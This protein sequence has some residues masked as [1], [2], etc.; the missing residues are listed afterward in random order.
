MKPITFG[1]ALLCAA[2][3]SLI[4]CSKSDTTPQPVNPIDTV[5][6]PPTATKYSYTYD[7]SFKSTGSFATMGAVQPDGKIIIANTTQVARLNQDGTL[8]NGFATGN[9]A[10]G[11]FHSLALQKDGKVLLGGSFTSFNGQGKA[12]YIRLNANGSVDNGFTVLPLTSVSAQPKIDI[13]S[14]AIQSDSKILLG[15]NFYYIVSDV[16]GATSGPRQIVRLSENGAYDP[17]FKH[18][19]TAS[20]VNCLRILADGKMLV[21]GQSVSVEFYPTPATYDNRNIV[22]KLNADG[23]VDP[24]FKWPTTTFAMRSPYT[25]LKAYGQTITVLDDGK[26]L[27]GGRFET[28][29]T[30]TADDYGGMVRLKADGSID[31]TMPKRGFTGVVS[32]LC[33]ASDRLVVG[34]MHDPEKTYTDANIAINQFNKDGTDNATF[35]VN[36]FTNYGDV[37][38]VLEDASKN[39][40]IFGKLYDKIVTSTYTFHGVVRLK[41]L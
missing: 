21:T 20:S 35:T 11:E 22:V 18:N 16:N 36:N 8:D 32:A 15:G 3:F 26:I 28:T 27:L 6:T 14:I 17:T 2:F 4:S 38:L 40:L 1:A 34:S 25:Y 5:T 31:N 9:A 33:L 23:S 37:Y 12:Y 24:S 39:L 29:S 41:R 13:R 30:V 10:G 19:V 7:S